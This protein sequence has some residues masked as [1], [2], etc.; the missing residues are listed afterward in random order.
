MK[1]LHDWND[2]IDKVFENCDPSLRLQFN[3]ESGN[4][5]F[6]RFVVR[7]LA[8]RNSP[9][10]KAPFDA[11]KLTQQ[12]AEVKAE[13]LSQMI[14]N[15]FKRN[16]LP[17]TFF[18]CSRIMVSPLFTD[19]VEELITKDLNLSSFE[20]LTTLYED[21]PGTFQQVSYLNFSIGQHPFKK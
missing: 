4:D 7:A 11:D 3:L 20:V 14:A 1:R 5:D 21:D 19:V 9:C 15:A 8:I 17:K 6:N 18:V 10:C 12:I 2:W 16:Y 13:I